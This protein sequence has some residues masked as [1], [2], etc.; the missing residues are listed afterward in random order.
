M[1]GRVGGTLT[2]ARDTFKFKQVKKRKTF[3]L[4]VCSLYNGR[5]HLCTVSSPIPRIEAYASYSSPAPHRIMVWSS[6]A[7]AKTPGFAGL[8]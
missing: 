2:L 6:L 5:A 1:L 3:L 4:F 7:L 8:Q